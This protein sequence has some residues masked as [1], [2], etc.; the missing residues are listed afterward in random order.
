[1]LVSKLTFGEC[2][3]EQWSDR[4]RFA[5]RLGCSRVWLKGEPVRSTNLQKK[6]RTRPMFPHYEPQADSVTYIFWFRG[7]GEWHRGWVMNKRFVLFS[8]SLEVAPITPLRVVSRGSLWSCDCW[9]R[10]LSAPIARGWKNYVRD[11]LNQTLTQ[12]IQSCLLSQQLLQSQ[13]SGWDMIATITTIFETK[14]KSL[15]L[16]IIVTAE[17]FFIRDGSRSFGNKP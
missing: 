11:D 12:C 9:G 14:P 3:S 17:R 8:T 13:E 2:T 16:T 7:F 6:K 1:M 10:T 5:R 4:P 15:R